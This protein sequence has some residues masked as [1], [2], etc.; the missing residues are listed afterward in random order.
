MH[1]A[2]AVRSGMLDVLAHPSGTKGDA[3]WHIQIQP[4]K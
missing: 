2:A 1:L 4:P 3:T